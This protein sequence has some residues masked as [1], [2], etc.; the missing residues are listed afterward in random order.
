MF[1]KLAKYLSTHPFY[2]HLFFLL[3]AVLAA[4][5]NGYHYGTFDQVFHITFL[6]K[7][8]NPNLYPNDP[9]LSLRWYHFSF[10]W[11]PFI[12]LLR[13]NLLEISMF[14]IH[15]M[16]V[17]G[18]FWM[19]WSLSELLFN[20]PE[21]NLLISFALIFPHIGL[22][23]FQIIEF[24]LLNRTFV[25]PFVLGSIFL[26]L[27]GKKYLAF[28]VL[29]LMFNLH[30]LYAGFVLCMF[31][32]DEAINFSWRSWR[33]LALQ[34]IIFLMAG[35]PV[36]IWRMQTGSGI[37]FT[38]RPEMLDLAADGLLSTVYYPIGRSSAAIG[39]L[40]AGIGTV[41]AFILGYH[42]APK[43]KK[44]ETMRNFA[45]AIGVLV[46]ISMIVSYLLPITILLQMQ[47]L[48][49]GVFMLYFSMLYF[50][51]FLCCQKSNDKLSPSGFS[52]SAVSFILLITPLFSILFYF[53][54]KRLDKLKLNPAWGIPVICLIQVL[55][56]VIAVRSEYWAPGFH[57]YG[58]QSSWQD[59]QEWAEKNTSINARFI[60]PPHKFW[61]YTPDWRVFSER[62]SVA[63]IPEMME[64]PFDPTFGESFKHRFKAVAPGALEKFNGDYVKT[65]EFTEE[66]FYTNREQDFLDIACTFGAEFLVVERDHPYSF[67]IMYENSGFIIYR[68][69]HCP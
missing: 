56:I 25:L 24:S 3:I 48:R 41:W 45:L 39:N 21:S 68:L 58:P 1:H 7:F 65:L 14:I 37:D 27:K 53:I 60:T 12:P 16:S 26:Y 34:F 59:V 52:M 8:V 17:Y 49:S 4:L 43:N 47:I 66:A 33:K 42:H 19:F 55:I 64:I 2:R 46:F 36:L 10:F 18:I 54:A 15:I 31:L 22:P 28:F 57:I 69:E 35:L 63:T 44:H 11:F 38:L 9:F 51:F 61:H 6:K 67:E 13:A 20:S 50:S 5:I 30:V 23:G 62:V 32:L 40:A 29:G